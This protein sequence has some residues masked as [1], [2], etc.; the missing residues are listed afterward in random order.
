MIEMSMKPIKML[1]SK[2]F[3]SIDSFRI[4]TNLKVQRVLTNKFTNYL[5]TR[6]SRMKFTPS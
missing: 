4:K 2:Q 6:S 3:R 1:A 5:F